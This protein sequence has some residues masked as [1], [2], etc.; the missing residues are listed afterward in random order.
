VEAVPGASP[1]LL[2]IALHEGVV[3]PVLTVGTARDVM[4]ICLHAGELVG[5]VGAEVVEAGT[6]DADGGA[7][8]L[9][10]AAVYARVRLQAGRVLA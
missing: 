8:P 6:F 3:L 10:L 2:G 1:E 4:V 7:E 9:D 5:L